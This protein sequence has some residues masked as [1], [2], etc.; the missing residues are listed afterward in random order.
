MSYRSWPDRFG[1]IIAAGCA[2]HCAALTAL[3]LLY[4]ALWLNR[5]YWEM[6]VWQKLLWLEWGLLA[7]SWLL[8]SLAMT[9][10]WRQHRQLGPAA[11]AMVGLISLS[12]V[13]L[14]SLHFS[15]RW[16][17]LLAMVAGLAVAGSHFWNLRAARPP[18]RSV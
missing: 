12:L 5:R 15:G 9:M 16:T 8:V 7:A 2:L 3:F 1:M 17:A 11:L 14:T 4:P 10:G 18:D 13:I 6:G